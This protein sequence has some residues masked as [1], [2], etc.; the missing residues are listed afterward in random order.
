MLFIVSKPFFGA[1]LEAKSV[2]CIKIVV[3]HKDWFGNDLPL[4]LVA[5]VVF[6]FDETGVNGR[7]IHFVSVKSD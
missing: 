7:N 2:F 6:C 4:E 1:I 3:L 5:L